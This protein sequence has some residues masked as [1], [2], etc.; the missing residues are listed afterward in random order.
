[1]AFRQINSKLGTFDKIYLRYNITLFLI[2]NF[3]IKT[4]N[5]EYQK[6]VTLIHKILKKI[7][8]VFE[9]SFPLMNTAF[10]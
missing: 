2:G 5:N 10:L 7:I 9:K 1:M 3:F 6:N 8:T 4:T